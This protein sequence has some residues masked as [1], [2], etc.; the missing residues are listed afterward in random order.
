MAAVKKGM[1]PVVLLNMLNENSKIS[2]SHGIPRE[3]LQL[4]ATSLGLPVIT[5]PA[6]WEDYEGI[7]V[8]TLKDLRSEFR[9]DTAVFG[10]IDLQEHREWEEKVCAT[11]G[12]TAELPLWKQDRKELVLKMI[13]E[14]IDAYVV[15][16][17]ITM[18]SN[19]IGR[20][21]TPGVI[22]EL[23]SMGV[24]LCGENG[25]YHTLVVNA[26]VFKER[27]V[28]KFGQPVKHQEYW[29]LEMSI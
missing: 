20:K 3:I 6:S 9:I 13:S 26:P 18:G 16:C 4:Q 2:R 10:D 22:T 28:V 8:A 7:F 25:E 11:A 15:S 19:F 21:I 17:N 27:V 29:F 24:D 1:E 14:G 5:K 23:E 12:I